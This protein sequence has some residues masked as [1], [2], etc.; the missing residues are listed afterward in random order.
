MEVFLCLRFGLAQTRTVIDGSEVKSPR[1]I[2]SPIFGQ[3]APYYL[4][5]GVK[6]LI[7]LLCE[8]EEEAM[9]FDLVNIGEDC[10]DWLLRIAE[11]KD[12][13]VTMGGYDLLFEG[14]TMNAL[15]LND[16][17]MITTGEE[18]CD[19]AIDYVGSCRR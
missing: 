19:K 8:K 9:L 7:C 13:T 14:K 18:W 17:T 10:E 11:V 6:T 16:N 1:C 12:I 5:G 4:S 3:I 2:I 15:C